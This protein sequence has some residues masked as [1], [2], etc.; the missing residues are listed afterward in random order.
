MSDVIQPYETQLR[1]RDGRRYGV[2]ACGRERSD[3]TW[4]GWLEF[5][6]LDGGTP[7]ITQRETTQPN[8]A[9]LAY[10][11]TGLTDPYLDGALLRASTELP[12]APKRTGGTAVAAGPAPRAPAPAPEPAT[13]PAPTAILDP[14]HVYAEGD[15]ILRD[16]LHA[17][18]AAQLRNIVRAHRLSGLTAGDLERLSPAELIDLIMAAVEEA[19]G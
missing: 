18:S 4:E 11:A 16:Q 5:L 10:W 13:A 12:P 15:E 2:Q 17:L 1:G 9:D 8:R 7:L 19:A 3:G 14:F 6:P